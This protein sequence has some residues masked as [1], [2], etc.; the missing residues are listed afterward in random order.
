MEANSRFKVVRVREHHFHLYFLA[1]LLT[2]GRSA[3][4]YSRVDRKGQPISIKLR[5]EEVKRSKGEPASGDRILQ[6]NDL[7]RDLT[8]RSQ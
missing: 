4:V 8:E 7:V 1:S 3:S 5:K 2:V 6:R